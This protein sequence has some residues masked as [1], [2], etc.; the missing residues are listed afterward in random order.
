MTKNTQ[1]GVQLMGNARLQQHAV[2]KKM[3]V[4]TIVLVVHVLSAQHANQNSSNISRKRVSPH[5]FIVIPIINNKI[6]H[7][8]SIFHRFIAKVLYV[9]FYFHISFH[10]N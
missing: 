6:G 8:R 10:I 9:L 5:V 4:H 2:R 7:Y 1:Y 3:N